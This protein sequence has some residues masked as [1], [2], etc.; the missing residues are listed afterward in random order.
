M[1]RK[2]STAPLFCPSGH[3]S[4][5]ATHE[6]GFITQNTSFM[7]DY[8]ADAVFTTLWRRHILLRAIFVSFIF[9]S[10]AA[11]NY[12]MNEENPPSE[13]GSYELYATLN[14]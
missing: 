6:L 5:L 7:H 14:Q 4:G 10:T 11:F 12:C 13:N 9:V 3:F 2:R 1:E 8:F